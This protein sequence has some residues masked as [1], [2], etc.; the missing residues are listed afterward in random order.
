MESSSYWLLL[1]GPQSGAKICYSIPLYKRQETKLS[2]QESL[3]SA[4][5]VVI[6]C[7]AWSY[8]RICDCYSSL[9][10]QLMEANV[11]RTSD[12]SYG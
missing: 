4:H 12:E 9:C 6:T 7:N 8:S 11:L 5:R 3:N 1:H 10:Q 2:M